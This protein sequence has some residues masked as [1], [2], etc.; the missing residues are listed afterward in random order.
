LMLVRMHFLRKTG[1]GEK[2]DCDEEKGR[3]HLLCSFELWPGEHGYTTKKQFGG[4][5]RGD[6]NTSLH[7]PSVSYSGCLESKAE[8][9]LR[10]Q[11]STDRRTEARTIQRN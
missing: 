11:R 9:K 10:G 6:G 8:T 3:F 2:E 1:S 5:G 7:P 4:W